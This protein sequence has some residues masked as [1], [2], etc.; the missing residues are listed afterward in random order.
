MKRIFLY[1]ILFCSIVSCKNAE[2]VHP[3]FTYTS[4]YFP[5]QFPVRT[6][7]LG[8]D[9][10]DN[11]NDN[12]HKFVISAAIGGVYENAIDRNFN[13]AL[14]ETLCK[15]ILFGANGDTIRPL[16]SN[17]YTLSSSNNLVVPKGKFNGG[18]EVQL[19]EAFFNDPKAI[20]LSY[21]VPLKLVGSN[22]VDSLI[23]GKSSS[24]NPDPR[25]A[26]NWTIAPKNF[27][28]FGIKYINEF[29]GNYFLHGESS[30]NDSTGAL[31]DK[32]VYREQ[33]VERNSVA[34]LKTSGR[35]QVAYTT[36]FKSDV[37][38]GELKLLLNFQNGKCTVTSNSKDYTVTGSGEFKSGAYEW[39]N[40]SRNG[41]ELTY[42]VV[43]GK[44]TYQAKE[45]LVARDRAVV[46]EVYTP[47]LF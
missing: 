40:K 11:S 13:I 27:T 20:Q 43:K 16:P 33:Y 32:K 7:I 25:I 46:M 41:I 2:I 3:D 31:V 47:R 23:T 9:I 6:L 42:T 30:L 21:V 5:Y 38:S 12:A 34:L 19:T 39:G 8:D 14:D 1:L 36:T 17:Y 26:G 15:D 35:N 18:I 28:M 10:Y 29:H 24:S 4:G 45:T 37:Q 22:D 44:N